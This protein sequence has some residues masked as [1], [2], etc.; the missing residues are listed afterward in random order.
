MTALSAKINLRRVF[1]IALAAG[2][3]AF[4]TKPLQWTTFASYVEFLLKLSTAAG[5]SQAVLDAVRDDAEAL[6]RRSG[7]LLSSGQAPAAVAEELMAINTGLAALAG[8]LG[9]TQ[10]KPQPKPAHGAPQRL[11]HRHI[12]A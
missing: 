12:V 5:R 7:A 3:T 11:A 9:S 1:A 10:P 6:A 4:L 2:A 8:M